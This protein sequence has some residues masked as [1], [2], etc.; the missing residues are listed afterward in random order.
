MDAYQAVRFDSSLQNARAFAT[1]LTGNVPRNGDWSFNS[2]FNES[3]GP[4]EDV[5]RRVEGSTT[6]T[7]AGN[8]VTIVIHPLPNNQAR[9]W[10]EMFET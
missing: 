4:S 5:L 8:S 3:W 2:D 7:P 1:K 10:L 6:R 9:V